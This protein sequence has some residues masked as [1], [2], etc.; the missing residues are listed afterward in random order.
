MRVYAPARMRTALALSGL[1]VACGGSPA[2]PTAPFDPTDA[3]TMVVDFIGLSQMVPV[4]GTSLSRGQT[5]AFGGIA[6]YAL[7]SA[8]SAVGELILL[9][10]ADQE[11]QPAG[12]NPTATVAKGVGQI[13]F[14]QTVTLPTAGISTVRVLYVLTPAGG[15]KTTIT[16]SYPVE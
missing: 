2:V 3:A 16:V 8:S 13:P 11:L 15:T 7:Y 10:Q 4:A 5:V 14:S 12:S 9:D 1:V 6:S